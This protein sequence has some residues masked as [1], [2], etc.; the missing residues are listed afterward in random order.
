MIT[1]IT[2]DSSTGR[3]ESLE[4]SDGLLQDLVKGRQ[5]LPL[6]GK[7]EFGEENVL[8]EKEAVEE[9]VNSGGGIKNRLLS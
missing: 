2:F 5:M 8:V 9:M 3:L 4:V 7:V 1:D 6:F